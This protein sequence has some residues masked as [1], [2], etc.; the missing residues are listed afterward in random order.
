[1][2]HDPSGFRR[3]G[4]SEFLNYSNLLNSLP[5]ETPFSLT[6]YFITGFRVA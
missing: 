2:I 5:R 1:M 4:R 6:Q 3:I